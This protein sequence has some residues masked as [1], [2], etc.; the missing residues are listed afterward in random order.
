MGRTSI[1]WCDFTFNPWWGCSKVSPGCVNCYAEG[2]TKWRSPA[3]ASWGVHGS[4]RTFG[5]K[6]WADPIKWDAQA[7]REGWRPRV[8]C[9]SMADVFE[10]HRDVAEERARLWRLIEQTP[11]L[12]WLLLTKRPENVRFNVPTPWM[13]DGFPANVW[14]GVSVEDQRRAEERVPLLL[15]LPARIRFL[16]CE[17]LLGPVTLRP[18][19][20][21]PDAIVCGRRTPSPESV[22]AIKSIIRA[23]ARQMGVPLLDWI[24]AGGESG[25][26]ARPMHP[27]WPRSLRDQ[28]EA[29]GVPFLFK[30]WG[31]YVPMTLEQART[32]PGGS[33]R[34]VSRDPERRPIGSGCYHLAHQLEGMLEDDRY[35]WQCP[36]VKVGK[37]EAGNVL[38][39][40]Q[41]LNWPASPA[42]E[43]AG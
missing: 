37:K 23:A 14:L 8:F 3:E 2:L 19:W 7:E 13:A 38:D 11:H 24:I 27:D 4:R 40:L 20:L 12:D 22:E 18:E 41:H 29:A 42:L 43:V 5:E 28:A 34:L 25:A 16:S 1:E 33:P 15:D 6:H 10:E 32:V 30:Q 26:K 39:G 21:R 31:A 36:V 35:R 9:A 17:P